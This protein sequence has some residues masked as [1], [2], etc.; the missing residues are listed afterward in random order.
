M[1]GGL[2]AAVAALAA[3]APGTMS[4][5]VPFGSG[6]AAAQTST[7]LSSLTVSSITMSTLTLSSYTATAESEPT[8]GSMTVIT[9][10]TLSTT[11]LTTSSL[12][13][14]SL[15]ISTL[16]LSSLTYT[17]GALIPPP[18]PMH[19]EIW[20][21]S[22]PAVNSS[23]TFSQP[24]SMITVG[25][26]DWVDPSDSAAWSKTASPGLHDLWLTT[27]AWHDGRA[28]DADVI[29]AMRALTATGVITDEWVVNK[30]TEIH[31]LQLCYS[32][33]YEHRGFCPWHQ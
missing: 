23:A 25:F 29:G 22:E 30:L 10:A 5:V 9:I 6:A 19:Y 24:L 32:G 18:P 1:L 26:S 3:P 14:S 8:V 27:R 33:Q 20:V 11:T 7:T 31:E 28:T 13:T 17:S 4:D 21:A 16:V 12:T 15:T 2:C